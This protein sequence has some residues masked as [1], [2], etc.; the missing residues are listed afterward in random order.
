MIRLSLPLLLVVSWCGSSQP[1]AL[2]AKEPVETL[3]GETYA[4][5]HDGPLRADAYL[6]QGEGPFPGVLVV[7]GG[8]WRMGSK[9]QLGGIARRLANNGY[10]AVAINYRLAPA[11]PFP[12]QV[13]DC[14]DA[15]RWMRREAPR[16]KLDPERIG[17]LGYSAGG[18]LVALLGALN[19]QT[20]PA[21]VAAEEA[22]DQDAAAGESQSAGS[23]EIDESIRLQAVIAGGAPCDFRPMPLD[24]FRLV[25]WLG[26]TRRARPN[27]YRLASPA[28]FVTPDD[29]PMFFYHGEAD[30]LVPVLSPQ[31]MCRELS[32]AGVPNDLFMV[33]DLGHTPSAGNPEALVRGLA[34]FEKHLKGEAAPA[35][36]RQSPASISASEA[37][38]AP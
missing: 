2:G 31:E 28:A 27:A 11:H 5:R 35:E 23:P 9:A 19:G 25:Y 33:A 18:H 22:D 24:S 13:L 38:A 37:G 30:M 1:P 8:A 4:E 34:F 10:T 16:L 15:L 6:P 20:L 29:P 14:Q 3:Y 7:H 12:A 32:D 26:G 17:G 36:D 21:Q